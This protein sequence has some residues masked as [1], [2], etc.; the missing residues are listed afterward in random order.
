MR[1]YQPH[2]AGISFLL[3]LAQWAHAQN[4]VSVRAGVDRQHI[5]IGQPVQLTLEATVPAGTAFSWYPLDS[6]AH[7]EVVD[8]GTIDSVTKPEG[9]LY[10]QTVRLTSFDSGRWAIPPLPLVIG[11]TQYLTDSITVDIGFSKFDP[12]QDYHDIKDIQDVENPY[13]KWIPWIVAVITSVSLALVIWFLRKKKALKGG[14]AAPPVILSPYEEAVKWLEELRLQRLPEN[15]Q[16]KAY[17]TG[18]NDI[19]RKFILRKL[20]IATLAKTNEELIVQLK[21]LPLSAEQFAQLSEALRISDSVKFAKYLPD[22]QD[23]ERNFKVIQSSVETLNSIQQNP[24][25]Q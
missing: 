6:I 25:Q 15:G 3:V 21:G 17:Y 5:L 4:T 18:L 1:K 14:Q 16:V 8:K 23:N 11:N 22:E 12:N 20:S 7:F 9:M 24:I 2:I 10:R 19:L 13:A